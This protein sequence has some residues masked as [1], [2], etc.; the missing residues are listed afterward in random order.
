MF[1]SDTIHEMIIRDVI[2]S[3]DFDFNGIAYH[4][5]SPEGLLGIIRPEGKAT[6]W[7]TRFDSLNDTHERLDVYAVL[8]RYVDIRY[9]MKKISGEFRQLLCEIAEKKEKKPTFFSYI[10]KEISFQD[11]DGSVIKTKNHCRSSSED[12]YIC[13]F[14]KNRDS[15]PMWNY[16]SKCQHYEGYSI[17]IDCGGWRYKV[18]H[19]AGFK[20]NFCS[21]VYSKDE[22]YQIFDDTLLKWDEI[23]QGAKSE[24]RESIREHIANMMS[25]M[26]YIFK[27]EHFQHEQE[28]R[29]I[30]QVPKDV[31]IP[32]SLEIQYRNS[33][34]YIVPY[35]E[36]ELPQGI[37]KSVTVAPLLEKELAKKNVQEMVKS[38]GYSCNV[39][40]SEVPIRF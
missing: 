22:K 10:G 11:T 21:V 17:S 6:L 29:A 23:Y 19:N 13:S 37:I 33:N 27:D 12:T 9:R 39:Y 16:Y 8:A 5:T 36:Y 30:L 32:N 14:S 35:V 7:F 1:E 18:Q 34:G 2:L 26:Q 25:D 4:Y 20:L 38:R 24:D 3:R 40:S 31:E 28:V 15:L